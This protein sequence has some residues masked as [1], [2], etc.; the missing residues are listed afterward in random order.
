[1][2]TVRRATGVVVWG[3]LAFG[4]GCFDTV[5]PAIEVAHEPVVP[6]VLE[7][8]SV[9]AEPGVAPAGRPCL[10]LNPGEI[11]LE[12]SATESIVL[13]AC[14]SAP[15]VIERILLEPAD[16]RFRVGMGDAGP[17]PLVLVGGESIRLDVLYDGAGEPAETRLVVVSNAGPGTYAAIVRVG[18]ESQISS[19]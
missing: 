10:D 4:T 11:E 19:R 15:L 2:A 18:P 9:D 14:T 1:M 5:P 7:P 13:T 12:P 8:S 3:A 17:L 6:L 16:A